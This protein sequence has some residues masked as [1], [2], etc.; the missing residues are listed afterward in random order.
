LKEHVPLENKPTLPTDSQS[1]V[2]YDPSW[3]TFRC[4]KLVTFTGGTAN[5]WGNDGGTRDGGALFHVTGTVRMRIIGI[6]ETTLVGGATAN[7]GTS[8]DVSGLLTQVADATTLQVNEIW[9][10]A[11]SDASIELSSVATEK[12]VANGLDVLLYNGTANI[13]AG[14]IR[15]LVSWH[16]VSEGSLV[17]PSAL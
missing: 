8:K 2:I 5:A 14:A 6:V 16:P 11:T 15:F 7:V 17:E 3:G 1:K 10:D 12:I 13:T 4:E 9:H